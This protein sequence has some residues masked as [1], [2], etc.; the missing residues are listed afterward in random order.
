[1][2]MA[3]D[4]SPLVMLSLA[5]VRVGRMSLQPKMMSPSSKSAI[6]ALY[7]ISK[8]R[9]RRRVQKLPLLQPC[10]VKFHC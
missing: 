3:M 6:K 10:K 9:L 1:M 8:A 4:G 5:K 7:F 2:A